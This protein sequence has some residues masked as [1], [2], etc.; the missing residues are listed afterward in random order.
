[1][2]FLLRRIETPPERQNCAENSCA[3]S[4]C[5]C[6]PTRQTK[7]REKPGRNLKL[8]SRIMSMNVLARWN[9]NRIGF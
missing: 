7:K 5:V 6:L 4:L 8:A 3:Y 1:M 9:D 2:S